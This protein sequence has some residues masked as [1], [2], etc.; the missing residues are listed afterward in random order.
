MIKMKPMKKMNKNKTTK[1]N[2]YYKFVNINFNI[3]YIIYYNI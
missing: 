1:Y 3:I 2:I